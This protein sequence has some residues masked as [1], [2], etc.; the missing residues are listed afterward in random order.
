M[1]NKSKSFFGFVSNILSSFI[2]VGVNLIK[3]SHSKDYVTIN[4]VSF[5]F[6]Y[7]FDNLVSIV[8]HLFMN[9]Q[10]DGSKQMKWNE[11]KRK[12]K[13]FFTLNELKWV[14]CT[15]QFGDKYNLKVSHSHT[16][17]WRSSTMKC[18][19]FYLFTYYHFFLF[20][21]FCVVVDIIFLLI[22]YCSFERPFDYVT[23]LGSLNLSQFWYAI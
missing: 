11:T 10:W 12:T 18:F 2:A 13:S 19:W 20:F 7:F 9:R 16:Q 5:L 21:F 22:S 15:R 3:D 4:I 1:D 6:L 14:L 17:N 23:S 8:V